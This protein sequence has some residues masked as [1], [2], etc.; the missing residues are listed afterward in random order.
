MS[1]WDNFFLIALGVVL[2][3]N[4]DNPEEAARLAAIAADAAIEERKKRWP[5]TVPPEQ[6]M[7]NTRPQ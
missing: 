3:E 5:N 1:T 6:R 4:G 2:H 7:P